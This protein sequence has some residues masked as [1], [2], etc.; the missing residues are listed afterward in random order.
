[1]KPYVILS[2]LHFHEWSAFASVDAGGINSRLMG[3]VGE[4]RR[5]AAELR[6]AGGDTMFLAGDIFHTRGSVAPVVLNVVM[7]EF[8]RLRDEGITVI[9]IP[10]NHDLA[11][12]DTA[13]LHNAAAAL[14]DCGVQMVHNPGGETFS[15][16][17]DGSCVHLIPWHEDLDV[18][19]MHIVEIDPKVRPKMDLILHAPVDGV[20]KGI[21]DHGLD[22]TWLAT[23]G[24]RN[25][26][27]GHYH[28]HKEAAPKVWSI[29]ALAHH[30]WNDVGTKAGFLLVG[31]GVLWRKSH[32]PGFIDVTEET[33]EDELAL[34][35][36]Q[37][38]ARAK[39][40]G[41]SL[42]EVEALR[43]FLLGAGAKGVII[44]SIKEPTKVREGKVV[45]SGESL[46]ASISSYIVSKLD[47]DAE[48]VALVAKECRE[49]L[50]DAEAI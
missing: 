45:K 17:F 3:L 5:A 2:D 27:S 41:A 30:T 11:I 10:G 21:P 46:S 25:V 43:E 50:M 32:L 33:A 29:G 31:E 35:V 9:A 16:A 36:D 24:F 4:V 19:R 23:L 40:S 22:P 39:V 38:Y 37:N 14:M 1:M 8:R 12:K 7:D 42:K 49:V 13:R 44:Q 28:N 15:T 18:L 34:L 20:I 6:E 26:F 48:M 47:A